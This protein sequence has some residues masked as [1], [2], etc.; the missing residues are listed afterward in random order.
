M[1]AGKQG[2]EQ[3]AMDITIAVARPQDA[4]V[5]WTM[6]YYAA[7]MAQ[8]GAT[9]PV[10]AQD[11]PYLRRYV[12][13]WG[14]PTDVGVIG[15]AG[16]QPIGAVW[17]RLLIG[18]HKTSGYIDDVTPELAAAVLP[19]YSGKGVGTQLLQAYLA[20]AKDRFPAVTLNVRAGNPAIHLYQRV[21][22]VVK[23]AIVNR[24][25]TTSY[26]MVLVFG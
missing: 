16:G 20:I 10:A 21:G 6:L 22:F 26:T 15:Y 24:V 13:E 14:A 9:S 23:E 1:G 4:D 5:L 25:G 3:N 19:V 12:A 2:S 11:H 18:D 8:D 7:Q 17:S